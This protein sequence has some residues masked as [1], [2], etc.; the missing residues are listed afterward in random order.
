VSHATDRD[1][2]CRG[3]ET[4]GTAATAGAVKKQEIEQGKKAMD[5]ASRRVED[6]MSKAQQRLQE[7]DGSGK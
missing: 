5:E 2:A 7:A 6:S 4:A 1:C 3:P